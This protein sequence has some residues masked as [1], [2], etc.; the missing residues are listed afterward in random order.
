MASSSVS[1][2]VFLSDVLEPVG[3]NK[4]FHLQVGLVVFYTATKSKLQLLVSYIFPPHFH[5]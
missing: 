1:I 2:L 3:G 4:P 5:S